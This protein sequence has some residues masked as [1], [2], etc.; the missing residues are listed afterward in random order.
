[1]IEVKLER[2]CDSDVT[3]TGVE[4]AV[5]IGGSVSVGVE[6][7]VEASIGVELSDVGVMGWVGGVGVTREIGGPAFV[8]MAIG[9]VIGVASCAATVVGVVGETSI[10]RAVLFTVA[11]CGGSCLSP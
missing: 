10:R 8:V 5:G 7:G 9:I 6:A 4:P 3:G 11:S 2:A 1:M